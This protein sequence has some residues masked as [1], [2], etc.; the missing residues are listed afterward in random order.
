VLEEEAE[1][2]AAII[3]LLQQTFSLVSIDEVS[4]RFAGRQVPQPED[5]YHSAT[6]P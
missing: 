1:Q 4:R 5:R 3:R 2:L 6:R